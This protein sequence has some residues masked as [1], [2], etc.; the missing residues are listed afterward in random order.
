MAIQLYR[1]G[2]THTVRGIECEL[3]NFTPNSLDAMLDEGWLKSPEEI[4]NDKQIEESD[5]DE[6][7]EESSEDA[8]QQEDQ[9]EIKVLNPVRQAAKD[10]GIEGYEIK[11]IKTLEGLLDELKD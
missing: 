10:A 3:K 11:R 7:Q 2:N 8:P 6:R 9:E 4:G 1:A 5:Q